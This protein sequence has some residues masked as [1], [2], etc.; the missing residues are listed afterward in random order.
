[1]DPTGGEFDAD[2]IW[3]DRYSALDLCVC[4]YAIAN[5][6]FMVNKVA[7]VVLTDRNGICFLT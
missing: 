3:S 4:E 2:L 6:P 5:L 1:M 7:S